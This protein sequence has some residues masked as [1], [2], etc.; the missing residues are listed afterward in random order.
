M[1][2]GKE[3]KSFPS[4]MEYMDAKGK[5]VDK[6]EVETVPDYHGPDDKFPPDSKVPYKTP[7]ANKKP[8][9]GESGLA[10]LGDDKLKYEPTKGS[11]YEVKKDVMKEYMDEKGKVLERGREDIKGE[12]KMKVPAAPSGGGSKYVASAVKPGDRALGELGDQELVYEPDTKNSPKVKSKTES[13]LGKTKGMSLSEFTKYMLKECGCGQV[14]GDDLPYVTAYTTGKF[15]PHPPE[16]IRYISILA[17]KNNGILENLVGQMISMGYLGKLLK[18]IFEHPQAYEELV[19]L[20]DDENDGPSRSK[21]FVG[22]MNNSYGKFLSN[23]ENM[24]ESVSSPIGFEEEMEDDEEDRHHH[25]EEMED[26]DHDDEEMG[27]HD[28]EEMDFDDE[29]DFDNDEDSDEEDMDDEDMGLEDEESDDKDLGHEE[30]DHSEHRKL[31]KKFA[32][33]HL[34]DAMRNHEHMFKK[35]K[36][37]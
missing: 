25:D 11:D 10:E 26:E 34:L 20:F 37:I 4:F 6:P 33:D 13:F 22:A 24:Y 32:H 17:D 8:A 14:E 7:V 28:D 1:K 3:A 9:A 19:S 30:V 23:Q 15:Q 12:Y 18:A 31:K 36:G 27:D 16:V 2:S 21:S 35:M 5:V 29:E